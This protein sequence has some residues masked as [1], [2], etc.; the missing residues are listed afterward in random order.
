MDAAA[1]KLAVE[2]DRFAGLLP[3]CVVA[4][5][6]TTSTTSIDPV[7]SIADVCEREKLWLH[8]DAAYAGSAAVVPELRHILDGCARAI[9]AGLFVVPERES[10]RPLG[11]DIRAAHHARQLHH[12]RRS[13]PFVIRRFSPA[14][15][16][17]MFGSKTKV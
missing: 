3:F 17:T 13:R 1:L 14:V 15:N 16:S 4:T 11:G 10:D 9:R 8:V 5:V 12:K 2:E 7:P 6:G